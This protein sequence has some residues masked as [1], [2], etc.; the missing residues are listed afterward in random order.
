MAKEVGI[1]QRFTKGGFKKRGFMTT[2]TTKTTT[3]VAY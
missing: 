3:K 1:P 2:T